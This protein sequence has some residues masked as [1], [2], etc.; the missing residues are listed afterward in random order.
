MHEPGRRPD[1][2]AFIEMV[3]DLLGFGLRKFRIE[4]GG[5]T[6]LRELFPTGAAASQADTVGPIDLADDKVAG[7]CPAK[8]LAFS[9]DTG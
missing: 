5:A 8:Q 6:P 1:A 9:I 7:T 4:Q 2:T 3:D